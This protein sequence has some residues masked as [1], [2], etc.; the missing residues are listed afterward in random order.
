[1]DKIYIELREKLGIPE[2]F[3]DRSSDIERYAK[4][5]LLSEDE[6]NVNILNLKLFSILF[7]CIINDLDRSI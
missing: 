6:S 3:F 7:S 5:R 4:L 2:Q 1:M